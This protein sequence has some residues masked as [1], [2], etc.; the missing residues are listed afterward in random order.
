MILD[1]RT[2]FAD[3][4]TL[5][6]AVATAN[7]GD[8]I[9]SSVAR[10]LGQRPVY[11]VIQ[12][13]TAVVGTTSTVQFKLVSDSTSTISTT[14]ATEHYISAA[15]PEATL[16]AG[17]QMVIPLPGESPAYERFLAIQTVNA[18]NVL[19]AGVINAFLTLDPSGNRSYPDAVN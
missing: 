14:T 16:V 10:D 5:P 8:I 11:L 13:D 17:F 4:V 9:D 7:V 12:V 6:T 3:A 2:E 18:V 19:T 15:I 1:E